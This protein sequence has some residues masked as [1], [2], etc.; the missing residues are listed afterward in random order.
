MERVFL[1][2]HGP[3]D[4]GFWER[5][6]SLRSPG[7]DQTLLILKD[8]HAGDKSGW[9]MGILWVQELAGD[10]GDVLQITWVRM[11]CCPFGVSRD[12]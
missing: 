10:A 8:L 1:W 9:Q 5:A 11:Q 2:P 7:G 12:G 6:A 3:G 4:L